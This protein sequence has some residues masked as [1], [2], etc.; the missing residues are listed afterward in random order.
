MYTVFC[1]KHDAVLKIKRRFKKSWKLVVKPEVKPEAFTLTL[2][3][4]GCACPLHNFLHKYVPAVGLVMLKMETS[5]NCS[6]VSSLQ[7]NVSM[8]TLHSNTCMVM[9]PLNA[10]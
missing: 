3:W 10:Q 8:T 5:S 2:V 6:T 9:Q 7:S 1:E 4:I